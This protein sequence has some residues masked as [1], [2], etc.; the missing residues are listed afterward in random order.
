M[1]K[2][3]GEMKFLFLAEEISSMI[4]IKMI[5]TVEAYLGKDI[6]NVVVTFYPAYF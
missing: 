6:T 5:E 1:I 3:E 4:L 2:Y